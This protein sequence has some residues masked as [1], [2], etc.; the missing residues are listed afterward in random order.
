MLQNPSCFHAIQ[1]CSA[2]HSLLRSPRELILSWRNHWEYIKYF[3][4]KIFSYSFLEIRSLNIGKTPCASHTIALVHLGERKE[5]SLHG[6]RG[7]HTE[8]RNRCLMLI[9]QSPGAQTSTEFCQEQSNEM[10]LRQ[11][12][13]PYLKVRGHI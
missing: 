7:S 8:H 1:S 4:Q 3:G 11:I 5:S 6:V 2:N 12:N 10:T 9:C 13:F